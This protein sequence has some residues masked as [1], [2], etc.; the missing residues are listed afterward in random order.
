MLRSELGARLT[1]QE[2]FE[3]G[4]RDES[5]ERRFRSHIERVLKGF[6]G[7]SDWEVE[8]RDQVCQVHA[9]TFNESDHTGMLWLRMIQQDK[10]MRGLF[11]SYEVRG[12]SQAPGDAGRWDDAWFQLTSEG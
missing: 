8:C 2:R 1:I 7:I 11:R 9:L 12:G 6:T 10:E 5:S 3:R 4:K